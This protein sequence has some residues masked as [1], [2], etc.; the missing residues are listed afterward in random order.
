M[1]RTLLVLFALLTLSSCVYQRAHHD[2][3]KYT[4]H[5]VVVDATVLDLEKYDKFLELE[6]PIL[7]NFG[8]NVIMDIR[9]SDQTRRHLIVAF[10]NRATVDEF[11]KSD[12][13]QSIL[14]LSK[15]SAESKISH[16]GLFR[17][18]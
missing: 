12:E 7:R 14:H 2:E 15:E 1:G 13:F 6:K 17:I 3:E 8:A 4:K 11:V 10:P 5:Y 9:N 18:D 16:G